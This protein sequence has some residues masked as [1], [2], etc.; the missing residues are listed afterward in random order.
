[1]GVTEQLAAFMV[2]TR[3][4]E[5]P[6]EV[7]GLT[8][9]F[10][11][12]CLGTALAGSREEPGRIITEYTREIGGSPESTL[13]GSG[14]RTSAANAALAN[15]LMAHVLDFDDSG[16]SHPTGC[17][18]PVLLSMGEKLRAS[19][20]E[21]L[22][23]H[24]MGYECFGKLSYCSRPYERDLRA[25]GY[26]PSP[27]WGSMGAAAAAAKLLRLDVDRTRMALG[28]AGSQ[29]AGL[30]ENFG[31]M[32]KG[33]H[34]GNAARAG[35][36]AALLVG[37][38]YTASQEIIEGKHGLYH[39]VVGEG[40]YDLGR[41]TENLGKTWEVVTPGLSVKRYPCCA[42]N[43]RALDAVLGIVREHNVSFSDVESVEV[44]ISAQRRDT[45]RF[46]K[47][48]CGFQGK[49]SMEYNMAAAILDG[50]V[51][52]ETYH[53]AKAHSS[54]MKEALSKVRVIVRTDWA[55]DVGKRRSPVKVRMRDGREFLNEVE[56]PRGHP[57]NPL[58]DEELHAKFRYC[59]GRAGL[60]EDKTEGT[61]ELVQRLETL[62]D[63]TSI[64]ESV[65]A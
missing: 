48:A 55:W 52:I 32:T 1:M 45:L 54:E 63:I 26:H 47:P 27:L 8:K 60:S 13:V 58:T 61:I 41:V 59:A 22:T 6:G 7:I 35:V 56:K 62:G 17:I 12:D 65:T 9:K 29:A 18:L 15:G 30:T 53:D 24:V 51:D 25:R 14:F 31:T 10:F 34:S 16:F 40:N 42:G 20:R 19:G 5:I 38:G 28:L 23:A 57:E 50:K 49:F 11:L 46:D 64:M 37:K 33:F 21:V 39:A 4:E 3:F 2:E 44:E 43:L 36:L